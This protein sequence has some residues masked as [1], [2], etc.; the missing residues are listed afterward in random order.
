MD[1]YSI[2]ICMGA[3][4]IE[5]EILEQEFFFFAPCKRLPPPYLN[6]AANKSLMPRAKAERQQSSR[7]NRRA[8]IIK[9]A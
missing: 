2:C 1:V 4:R 5:Y 9:L 6:E 7:N 3:G 8:R